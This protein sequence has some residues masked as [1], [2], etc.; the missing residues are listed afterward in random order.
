M[1]HCTFF[2]LYVPLLFG[3]TPDRNQLIGKWIGVHTEWDLDLSCPL[4]IYLQL[5]ADGTYQFGMIEGSAPKLSATWDK[6]GDSIRL[7]T[8]RY[9][10]GV[11][12]LQQ[13]ILRIGKNYPMVFRRFDDFP[14]DS[15]QTYKTLSGRVWQ[16]DSLTLYLFPD[17]K[18]A[19][20][21]TVTKQRTA[22]FWRLAQLEKS[23]FLVIRGNQY[24]GEGN[25]KYIRQLRNISPTSL[26]FIGSNGQVVTVEN[27]RFLRSLNKAD[28]CRPSGFQ[29]CSNCY[30]QSWYET[31][32]L[33]GSQRYDLI[34]LFR[35]QY[36]PLYQQ[37]ESGLVRV[38][39][40]VNC[41]GAKGAFLLKGFGEDYCPRTFDKRVLNQILAI[42]RDY[43]ATDAMLLESHRQDDA[44]SD[45]AV[46]LTF[47]LKNGQI[48]EILP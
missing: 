34:Q 10:P 23:V 38:Q 28:T 22:H 29:V 12:S 47:R 7:D 35:K 18:L 27:F 30:R 3:Q 48:T 4:P 36:Q 40:E 39:F 41:K 17:G 46:S 2:I 8:I 26:Q 16:S 13:N 21:N 11:I 25:C 9:T 31:N 19:M 1:I 32:R 14:L 43:V 44:P 20:E 42:C 24:T 6:Q 37:G 5:D 15:A 33:A 45:V